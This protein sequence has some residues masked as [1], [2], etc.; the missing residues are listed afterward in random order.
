MQNYAIP[1]P[2]DEHPFFGTFNSART[3]TVR[4]V[5]INGEPYTPTVSK[6]AITYRFHVNT[7]TFESACETVKAK[8]REASNPRV[9]RR[10]FTLAPRTA[11]A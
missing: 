4:I 5:S 9:T 6:L 10:A 1:Q 7:G 2:G 8:I 11:W 3:G